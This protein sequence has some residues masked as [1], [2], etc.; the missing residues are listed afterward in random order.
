MVLDYMY[1]IIFWLGIS[2]SDGYNHRWKGICSDNGRNY[3]CISGDCH[4]P[5]LLEEDWKNIAADFL[6]WW[7]FPNCNRRETC[8]NARAPQNMKYLLQLQTIFFYKSYGS[9]ED[10]NYKF[11]MD[12]IGAYGSNQLFFRHANLESHGYTNPMC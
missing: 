9:Y 1:Y 2:F 12:N 4:S 3:Q 8:C 5:K 6:E 10:A 7:N 11:I